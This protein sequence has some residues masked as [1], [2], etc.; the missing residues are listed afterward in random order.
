MRDGLDIYD[1]EAPANSDEPTA[2]V[3]RA[4][5]GPEGRLVLASSLVPGDVIDVHELV[6]AAAA[7][8]TDAGIGGSSGVVMN[9]DAVM[10]SGAAT[11]NEC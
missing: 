8:G 2:V 3:F 7:A 6:R 11:A 1:D 4:D 9:V 10:L 5:D